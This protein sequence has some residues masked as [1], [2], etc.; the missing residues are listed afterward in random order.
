VPLAARVLVG[1]IAGFVTGLALSQAPGSA[2]SIAAAATLGALFINLIR[3]TVIP[4]VVSMLVSSVGSAAASRALARAG[5]RAAAFAVTLLAVA[6]IL[7]V[8]IAQPVLSSIRIDPAAATAL[9]ASA[10][11][12]RTTTSTGT[13]GLAQWLI[14]LIPPNPIKAAADGVMLPVIVF[15][16][17]FALALARVEEQRRT[18]VL[19]VV[20]GI[21]G[22][23]QRLV[24]GILAVAPI[25]VFALAVPLAS[26][27]GVSAAGAVVAYIVLVVV[28]TV[29]VAVVL[30][31]PVGIFMGSMSMRE[32]IDFCAPAQAVAF[33]SRTSLAALPVM[34]ETAERAKL[35]QV[36]SR[37]IVPLGASLFRI[38][39]AVAQ[40]VGVLFLARLYGVAIGP[41]EV[42]SIVFTV[43]L[44]SF[45]VPGIPFGSIIAMVPVLNAANVPV[46]GI[47]ILLAVDTIPDMF[48]TTENVTG[49]LALAS[50][51]ARTTRRERADQASKSATTG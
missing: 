14:D 18:P 1:L 5:W 30:L 34:V 10:G 20:D 42:A 44:T 4:L 27:L 21:A 51:L 29:L 11:P 38:G 19:Q 36:V 8:A 2:Q 13:P 47:G 35:P 33:A 49:S 6:A 39:A 43:V 31:Y 32:F 7:T 45:A 41:A 26:T 3:M 24:S 16:V 17:L 23:M 48:R 50:V 12:P 28:L 37:V 46:E 25:G 22:A 40:P 15:A 9:R